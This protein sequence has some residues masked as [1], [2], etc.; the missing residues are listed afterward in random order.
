MRLTVRGSPPE[1]PFLL[2]T[3]HICWLD[4][5]AIV[6]V[7]NCAYVGMG[8]ASKFPVVGRIMDTGDIIW[9]NRRNSDEV[10]ETNDR[11][12]QIL[13]A[14]R[15]IMFC[16]EGIISPGRDVRKFRAA[17][18]ECAARRAR[19]VHYATIT[20]RTPEGYPPPSEVILYGPDP[21]FLTSRGGIPE[22][23]LELWGPVKPM[24]PYIIRFLSMPSFEIDLT[25]GNDP[26]MSND[27]I[28]LA[29]RLRDAVRAQLI[30]V[31]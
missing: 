1:H 13:D 19:P 8:E 11:M 21:Y 14:G 28:A 25:F 9:V 4:P 30:P 6:R 10:P 12:E 5:F 27:R 15:G 16:P 31:E 24:L 20:Y 17:L 3:N 7:L 22:S 29:N 18:L 26:I 23:E 2:V